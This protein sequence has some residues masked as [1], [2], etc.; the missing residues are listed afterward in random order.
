MSVQAPLGAAL[1]G[2]GEVDTRHRLPGR[3]PLLQQL[4]AV[5]RAQLVGVSATIFV[6]LLGLLLCMA[7]TRTPSLVPQ[8]IALWPLASGMAGPL[9]YV[10]I[11]LSV[12]EVVTG[13][14]AVL[15][16]YLVAVRYSDHVPARVTIWAVIAFTVIVLVGPPMFS[17]DVFSYQAYARM[18]AHYHINPYTHGPDVIQLDPLY[19]YIGAKW[20]ATPSVY[21]PLFTLL[22]AIF[23]MTSVAFNEFAFKLIAA[24][25]SAGTMVFIWK[26]AK[27]RG[28]SQP[29]A[30]ALFGLNPLVTLYGVGGGHNDLLMLLLSTAGLYATL[31]RRDGAA[32]GL[33]TTAAAVKLTGAITLPFALAS[34]TGHE[35]S[36]RKRF[37]LA[38]AAVTAVVAAM[39]YLAFGTGVL[40]LSS[41]LQQVQSEGAWQSLPG[42]FFSIARLPVSHAVQLADEAVLAGIVAWLLRRVWQRRLDWIEGAAWAT[43]AVLATAWS[44]LP[45]YVCWLMPLVALTN[46]RRLWR[47]ATVAT[48]MGGTIMIA[49]AFPSWNWL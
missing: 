47:I 4:R 5:E 41:T 24:L 49:G 20:I 9:Q 27:R 16:A 28:V 46:N 44:L 48:L 7:G 13:L 21:G 10:G 39:S 23:A 33:I 36:R 3:S 40:H 25:A 38:T 1:D 26:A 34:E 30:L 11:H 8:S 6:P 17:T 42:F 31:A 14:V 22:S 43:F 45:W 15:A 37:V 18:F 29:R 2:A 12:G 35:H 32:G 19:N